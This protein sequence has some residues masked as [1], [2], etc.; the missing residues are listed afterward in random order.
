MLEII[1]NLIGKSAVPVI[2]VK[3]ITGEII[4]ADINIFPTIAVDIADV[5]S[6]RISFP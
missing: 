6:V 4:V 5:Q 3:K 1:V 2:D